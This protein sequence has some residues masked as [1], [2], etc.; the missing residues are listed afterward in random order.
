M[1]RFASI[2]AF[3]RVAEDGGFTAAARHLKLS[4]TR[5]SEQVQALENSLGVRL[6][7]RTTRRVSLTEIGR[8]Y[9]ERCSQI[10]HE[11]EEAD[12]AAS[13]LQQTPRGQL[14]VYCHQGL[15]RFVGAVATGLLATQPEISVD[16]RTGHVMVDL[17]HEGFDL[18]INPV[19]PPDSTLVRRR[20]AVWHYVVCAAPA[21]LEI[22]GEP[23]SPGELAGHNCLLYTHAVFGHDWPFLD[24]SGNTVRVPVKGNLQTD[25][26]GAMRTA[27]LAGHGLWLCPPYIISDLVASG[28]LVRILKDHSTPDMEIVALYPHRRYMTAKVRIFIDMLAEEFAKEQRRMASPAN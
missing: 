12:E 18:A 13:A 5:V 21:Y 23:R 8:E 9:Y 16:L 3:V 10:L 7:N 25:S 26:I 24:G 4:T 19:P 15:A 22:H 14:R 27:V 28:Q 2:A 17:V 1:D 20:L 6:L 11:L